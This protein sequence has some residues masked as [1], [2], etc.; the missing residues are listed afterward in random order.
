M[1]RECAD[2]QQQ[3]GRRREVAAEV[4]AERDAADGEGDQAHDLAE[5]S[6]ERWRERAAR[7]SGLVLT[8]LEDAHDDTT[9]C[10]T[11]AM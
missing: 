4:G 6:R 9:T 7:E 1:Q 8:G 3:A 5:H 11:S 2:E 10:L